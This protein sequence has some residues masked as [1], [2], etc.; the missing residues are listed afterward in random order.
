MDVLKEYIRSVLE[1]SWHKYRVPKKDGDLVFNNEEI[2]EIDKNP[3][4]PYQANDTVSKSRA[5][6]H[7]RTQKA[8]V[9]KGSGS[10]G[11]QRFPG[12]TNQATFMSS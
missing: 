9:K 1:E 4:N 11:G 3:L 6:V 10:P 2:P 5:M 12:G 8:G 7:P